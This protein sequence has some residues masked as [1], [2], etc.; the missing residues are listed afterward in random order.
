MG[1]AE[2]VKAAT[3]LFSALG[4]DGV[5]GAMI[6]EA[7]GVG[8]GAVAALGGKQGVYQAVMGRVLAS[9][10][11]LVDEMN[12][13]LSPDLDGLHGMVDMFLEFYRAH[14]EAVALWQHRAM[15]DAADVPGV[16]GA[17]ASPVIQGISGLLARAGLTEHAHRTLLNVLGW[18][19]YGFVTI[20]LVAP[21]G[22]TDRWG[23]PAARTRF[24]EEVHHLIDVLGTAGPPPALP[25]EPA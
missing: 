12:R 15:S 25:D 22:T 10:I 1:E 23:D 3:G 5:T 14:P 18:S 24:R 13:V 20:G 8:D 19:F 6:A 9:Q 17:Y 21:D 2:I 11:A 16:E 4:Y 7:A